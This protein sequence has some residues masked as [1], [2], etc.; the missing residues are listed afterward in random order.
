MLG[1][2]ASIQGDLKFIDD[3]DQIVIGRAP[4]PGKERHVKRAHIIARL[5]QQDVDLKRVNI[6]CPKEVRILSNYKAF[7]QRDM[8][9]VTRQFILDHMPWKQE[10]VHIKDFISQPVMLPEG[11]VSYRFCLPNNEDFIGRFST[12][13]SFSVDGNFFK[14]VRVSATIEVIAPVVVSTRMIDRHQIIA[15][16]DITTATKDITHFPKSVVTNIDDII[17]KRAKYKITPDRILKQDMVEE[18]P[19]VH[20][21][22]M[23][24][25]FVETDSFRITATGEALEDGYRGD[26]I[27]V[28]NT[29]YN[30][31]LYGL[32][33]NS[34]EIEVHY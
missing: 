2:I 13:I 14:K 10:H 21:G 32:V 9:R 8:E 15:N 3:I 34:K 33:K 27:Q 20:K 19:D 6:I 31:K 23:V 4:L 16:D 26:K 17:G 5:K 18:E 1:E 28:C 22:D 12:E 11:K 30:N 29:T 24:T 25:I 7:S